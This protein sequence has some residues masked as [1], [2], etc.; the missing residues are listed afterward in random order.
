MP[1]EFLHGAEV[2]EVPSGPRPVRT[3]KSSVIGLVGTAAKGPINTPTLVT[4]RRQGVEL[5]GV[6]FGTI[7]DAL[8]DVYDQAGA[9]VVVINVF[10]DSYPDEAAAAL[11]A[12]MVGGVD[13]TTGAYTG[14]H[15]LL[16]AESV[17]KVAPRIL[18]APGYTGKVTAQGAAGAVLAEMYGIADRLRAVIITDGPNTTD[19]AVITMRESVGS[20]RVFIVDPQ[21]RVFDTEASAEANRPASARVAGVIAK[22]DAERGFWWSPS[23]RPIYG[24]VGTARPVD[25]AL[26]DANARA[27]HLNENEVATIIRQDGFRLWGNRTCSSDPKWAFLSVVRTADVINDSLQRA[28]LWAVDR[29][30]GKAYVESVVESVNAY[31]R[32]LKSLGAILGGECWVDREL[33]SNAQ[34]AQGHVTF[35]FDFTPCYPAERVTFRSRLVNDY[36]EEIF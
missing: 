32:D 14:V 19:A 25:F 6:G 33:N 20:R 28:H 2:V 9:A 12:G 16:A 11:D 8:D 34:I 27:N 26:G 10:D 13:A 36:I 29:C 21:V 24:I 30:I 3:V 1:T 22:S 17:A 7:P 23:N 18:I 31:L 15:A 35:D 5:F 4:S